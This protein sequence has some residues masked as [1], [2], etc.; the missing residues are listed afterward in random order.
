[1]DLYSSLHSSPHRNHPTNAIY[2]LVALFAMLIQVELLAFA[3]AWL[4]SI[5]A[6]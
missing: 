2:V 4:N 6:V 5:I 3:W 1:M